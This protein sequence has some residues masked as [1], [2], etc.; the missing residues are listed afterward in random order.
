MAMH[1]PLSS[2]GVH[3]FLDTLLGDD[4][5]ADLLQYVLER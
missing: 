4:L 1:R 5:H 2:D 3:A